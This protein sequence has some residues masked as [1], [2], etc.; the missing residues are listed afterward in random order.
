[1]FVP[2]SNLFCFTVRRGPGGGRAEGVSL[3]YTAIALLGLAEISES[4]ARE[5]LSGKTAPEVGDALIAQ[6]L[7]HTNLG[8]VSLILWAANRLG[9]EGRR[10]VL[11]R[12]RAL[13]PV[14]GIHPT[15]E[16]AWALTALSLEDAESDLSRMV[17]ARLMSSFRG[18]T[19]PHNPPDAP[20]PF[21]RGHVCC[22]ADLVYPT[23]AL[24]HFHRAT[25]YK[26]AMDI[27]VRC[28]EFMCDT[29]GANGQWWWHFDSRTGA[30]VE[31]YPVYA[32]H[33]DSMAPM[34][35]F[36]LGDACTDRHFRAIVRGLDWLEA[37]P[38]LSGRS[39]LDDGGNLIWRKVARH[40]P[41]KLV[42]ALNAAA[43]RVH[44]NLRMP[45]VDAIFKPG[46]V[47]YE[48]RPY[49]LGWILY[50]WSRPSVERF[51]AIESSAATSDTMATPAQS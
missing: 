31:G 12:L 33:Q 1:M 32:V 49:H 47:D 35:F 23:Q 51:T 3:R 29:Q 17:A 43:S 25:G 6:S 42:R 15:V 10:Q 20:A 45:G 9:L 18:G 34:A 37:A 26:P 21:L 8:N 36:D 22:F 13:D 39:L 38:E 7:Y 30:V 5:V 14:N 4:Q 2:E 46:F 24:A 50:A 44:R 11:E 40:E 48:C 19:F 41:G 16:I 27:A 28:A